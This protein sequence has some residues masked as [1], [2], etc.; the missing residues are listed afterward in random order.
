MQT[1][2]QYENYIYV[3]LGI[4]ALFAWLKFNREGFNSTSDFIKSAF[5]ETSGK[6]SISRILGT[7]VTFKILSISDREPPDSWMNMFMI[8]IGYQLIAGILKDNPMIME[9][10][11][12][13]MNVPSMPDSKVVKTDTTTTTSSVE[14]K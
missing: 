10:F 2:L 6:A 3:I 11:R 5:S 14:N 4:L 13:K 7:I 8:F 1:F 12:M 9:Y